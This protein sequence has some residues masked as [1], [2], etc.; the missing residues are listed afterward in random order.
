MSKTTVIYHSADFDGIFC[1][2]IARNF[3]GDQ[4][5]EYIGWDHGDKPLALPTSEGPVIIMDLPVDRVFGLK[6]NPAGIECEPPGCYLNT[7][8]FVWID[9]HKS[10]IDTHPT[11][12][13]GYRIDGV[14]A[15]RLAW[16]WFVLNQTWDP[17]E[18]HPPADLPSKEQFIN[19]EVSE[20][21]SVRLAGEYDVWD[22]RDPDA[23]VFQF[24]LRGFD[25][26]KHVWGG[27]L[28]TGRE[29]GGVPW[30]ERIVADMLEV[31]ARLQRYQQQQDASVVNFRSFMVEFEGLKFLALNT[32]RCNSLT[33]A[34]KDVP[35][36]G[37]DALMGFYFAGETWKFSLYHARHNMGIDLSA[38][39]VKYGGGGH[40]GAC[41][42]QRAHSHF[43]TIDGALR[44]FVPEHLNT[45][46]PAKKPRLFYY[47]EAQDAWCP[48]PDLT[49]N[50]IST[51][52]L[53]EGETM[54]LR[55][56]RVDMTDAEMQAL[57]EA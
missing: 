54:E 16:Q 33:F 50:M 15:C 45:A 4:D 21:L 8:R 14:S 53:A 35:E 56:K 36:T 26:G 27:L 20:P 31:G 23:E 48:A 24:G 18:L 28:E 47:E 30:N 5:V 17:R 10:A 29:P 12:I 13:P 44:L 34:A 51:D 9:H 7:S 39:A 19:R 3:L 41:G 57:P 11:D 22:K 32:A 1:R 6:A 38:I 52:N 37:H 42:F 55:F 43:Q 49:E 46:D 40:R 2:E 25:L